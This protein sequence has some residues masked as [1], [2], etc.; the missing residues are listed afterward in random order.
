MARR[1]TTLAAAP[2]I[3]TVTVDVADLITG[4][5]NEL[6][7]I[8]FA[9]DAWEN[10]AP[11]QYGVVTLGMEPI[12]QYA[13]GHLVDETY[14]CT[15]DMYTIGSSDEWP[16][17]VREKLDELD[18]LYDWLDLSCRMTARAYLFDIDKVQWTFA[19][20][21][22]GPLTRTLTVEGGGS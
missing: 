20:R 2:V 10:K 21:F 1:K 8:E 4:K 19:V 6:T 3:T 14:Q 13:D 16:A 7:G 11:D 22:H 12:A 17:L 18:E 9:R 5:L 15:V